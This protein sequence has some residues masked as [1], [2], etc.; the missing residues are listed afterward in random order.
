MEYGLGFDTGGTYTDAV[1]VDMES[2]KILSKAKALTTRDDLSIG[3]RNSVRNMDPSFFKN[4][5]L[6]SMSS[7]LATNSIVEGKGCRVGLVCIGRDYDNSIPVDMYVCIKGG[8]DLYGKEAAA[9]DE[10]TARD[11]FS[12][13]KGKVDGIAITGYLS[14]RNPDHENR[15][16]KMAKEMLDVPVVCGHQ[17]SSSL[18]F[19]ER[20]I[21]SIMNARLIPIIKDLMT[22]VKKV[23]AEVGIH[24]PMM[25]VKG[26]G[27]IMSEDIA[28]E[29]PIE[30]ILSG[31][32]ASLVGAKTLTGK[33]DAIVMDI[34][35]TTTDIGI[36]RNGQP[37]L[38]KEGAVI[39]GRRTRVMAAEISTSGIGGDS[40]IIV[41]GSKFILSSVRVVPLCIAT[42]KYPQLEARLKELSEAKSRLTPESL[43]TNNI[44]Q[45]IEYFIKL[46]DME[47]PSLS[48]ADY[49]LLDYISKEPFSLR[50]AGAALS[51]HPFL[52]N[53]AKMEELGMV[54]RIGLTPTDILHAEGTYVEYNV[55][56]SK[57]AVMHQCAKLNMTPERFIA[58]TKEKVIE[59]LS[60]ELLKKLF[61]EENGTFELD[62]VS[63]DMMSKFITHKEGLDYSCRIHLN[64]PIIG[65]G[66][67][68]G[69]YLPEVARRFNAELILPEYSE[70]GNA[71]GAICGSIIE[72]IDILIKPF[73]GEGAVEDPRCTVFASF[74]RTD[75]PKLSEA[76]KAAEEIGTKEVTERAKKAGAEFIEIKTNIDRRMYSLTDGYEGDILLEINMK[77]IATGKAKQFRSEEKSTYY[78]DLKQSWDVEQPEA[79]NSI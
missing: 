62:T 29:R 38:E 64:K 72:S 4:V 24:C 6:V 70:V 47:N 18:G 71:V 21:T 41:N 31:P 45:D 76:L 28:K 10:Q 3:I 17:L 36:L 61:Y 25:V 11:F 56:A 54:Q 27:S 73:Q 78:Q 65:V 48:E 52:F 59:K 9:L 26:D 53:I 69:A 39:G 34:G 43:N 30:T 51:V 79:K 16:S 14:V 66:A 1:L 37:R 23:M 15:I 13:A 63:R 55:N 2:G 49:R 74:G 44:V 42:T 58:F 57:Y 40:R 67:P 50:E 20:T 12:S 7:T 77:V 32:A 19:N 22:S 33:Q 8:H 60:E 75:Y 5:A 68:V 35:G 46:R